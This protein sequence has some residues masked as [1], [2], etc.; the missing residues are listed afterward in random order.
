MSKEQGLIAEIRFQL[1]ATL[2]GLTVSRPCGDFS[3]YDFVID[4][5]KRLARV[6]V[7]STTFRDKQGRYNFNLKQ[8]ATQSRAYTSSE[9]HF[10]ALYIIPLNTFY[11][12]PQPLLRGYK[13]LKISLNGKYEIFKEEWSFSSGKVRYERS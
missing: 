8:G 12:I 4:N 9:V 2:K 7:K 5:G 3:P 10:F 11:I 13:T 1:A 6:Q